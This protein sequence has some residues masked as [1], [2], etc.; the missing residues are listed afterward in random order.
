MTA[1][2]LFLYITLGLL[3]QVT[4]FAAV[5]FSRHWQT[6]QQ[7]RE[8]VAEFGGEE[9]ALVPEEA[10]PAPIKG[11]AWE[12]FREFRVARKVFEDR[13]R[14]ICS[15]HLVPTDGK[16]LLDFLP[17]QFLTFRLDPGDGSK[18]VT[19]CYSLSDRPGL[20]HYRVS[21]KRVS[22]PGLSSGHF[23]DHVREGDIL[24]A[25]AP[26]GHFYLE[27]GNSPVVLVAGGIGITPMLSMLN[28][29]LGNGGNREIWLFYGLRDGGEHVMKEHLEGLAR[30]HSNFRLHVCYSRP[31]P[32]DVE[33]RDYHHRGHVDITLLRLTLALRPYDFYICGPR[34]MMETLVPALEEWGVPDPRIHYEAF[35]PASLAKPA[36]QQVPED[37]GPAVAVT[38]AKSDRTLPW[39]GGAGSLL[40]FA[41][42]HGIKVDSGCRAGGCGSCQTRIEAGEVEYLQAPDYEPEPGTCLLCVSRPKRDLVLTA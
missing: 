17:G 3:L 27:R 6:Y 38:F 11:A 14:S 18:P 22:P 39:D 42:R 41:E 4:L 1:F 33:G 31:A 13:S 32:T 23:H 8:R 21:I 34:A 10:T 37:S 20:D 29:T 7:L 16:P 19:R 24:T 36:R 5:A 12:G 28:A 30:E 26:S 2:E 25:R 9:A 35:G 15:F 40:E